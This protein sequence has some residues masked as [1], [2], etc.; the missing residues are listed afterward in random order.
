[1]QTLQEI[2]KLSQILSE[3][4]EIKERG[5]AHFKS[6]NLELA[7]KEYQQALSRLTVFI[8]E[9]YKSIGSTSSQTTDQAE[10]K[11]EQQEN[12]SADKTQNEEQSLNNNPTI[13][14]TLDMDRNNISKEDDVLLTEKESIELLA[15]N[16][17]VFEDVSN[18]SNEV[19][20]LLVVLYSNLALT[21]YQLSLYSRS[22]EY[23]TI[24]LDYLDQNHYKSLYKRSQCFEQVNNFQSSYQDMKKLNEM[25]ME[26][27]N[28]SSACTSENIIPEAMAKKILEETERLRKKAEEEQ[29]KQLDDMLG[30]LKDVGNQLLG[31]FGLSLDNFSLNKDPNSGGYS[32]SMKK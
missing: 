11:N 10:P 12:N 31:A 4:N 17:N 22:L 26:R 24:I 20:A 1:M 21:Y 18:K 28:K 8:R 2:P 6:R 30:Q 3:C 29:K 7:E 16:L 27:K 32:I 15:K 23:C 13:E 5:N 14:Q 25:V 19:K 9:Y